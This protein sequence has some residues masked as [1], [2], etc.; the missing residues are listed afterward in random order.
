MQKKHSYLVLGLIFV[1][2]LIIGVEMFLVTRGSISP[3]QD[4]RSYGILWIP[5]LISGVEGLIV[6]IIFDVI[7]GF[8]SIY[9]PRLK[10]WC[11][12][13]TAL[14]RENEQEKASRIIFAGNLEGEAGAPYREFLNGTLGEFA[15]ED[16]QKREKLLLLQKEKKKEA[17]KNSKRYYF[18]WKCI[19]FGGFILSPIIAFWGTAF[20]VSMLTLGSVL[21]LGALWLIPFFLAVFGYALMIYKARKCNW[22][23]EKLKK[24]K[25]K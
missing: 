16:S 25:S 10:K 2:A 5:L 18:L 3:G 7:T 23:E 1:A 6:A 17:S 9:F 4:E 24:G 14:S 21:K 11:L 19:V 22:Y 8:Y 20:T 12:A 15:F 13:G